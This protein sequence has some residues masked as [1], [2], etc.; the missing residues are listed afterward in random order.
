M[1]QRP[2][3]PNNLLKIVER[4]DLQSTIILQGILLDHALKLVD[5]VPPPKKKSII[6]L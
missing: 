3:I 4:L 6:E 2:N 1:S 5:V